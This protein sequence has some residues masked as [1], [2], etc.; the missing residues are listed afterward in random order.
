M[1]IFFILSAFPLFLTAQTKQKKLL[2]VNAGADTTI[3]IAC[4]TGITVNCT[5]Y[6][7]DGVVTAYRWTKISGPGVQLIEGKTRALATITGLQKGVYYF[8]I[9][10]TDGQAN[11]AADTIMITARLPLNHTY[12]QHSGAPVITAGSTQPALQGKDT[13]TVTGI[14]EEL[15]LQG[16]DGQGCEIVIDARGAVQTSPSRFHQPEWFDL[17]FVKLLGLKSY[18]WF[19]TIK[20]S[21][22]IND[23]IIESC[24]FI[25]PP[26]QYKNQPLLQFDNASYRQMIFKDN[27][28]QT[29]YNNKIIRSRIEGFQDIA[30]VIFGS[31]WSRGTPEINRSI[32]LDGEMYLDTIRNITNTNSA[33]NVVS[34]TGFNMK[35]HDCVLD[36]TE[37]NPGARR[38]N[39]AAEVLW[40]GSI[41]FYNNRM[42][43]NY[44]AALRSIALGWTGLPGYRDASVKMYNNIIH[45]QLSYSAFEVGRN[46]AGGRDSAHGFLPIPC[47]CINNTVDSTVR[48][49]YN[50]DYYGYVLDIVNT[51]L[52]NITHTDSVF[53]FNNVVADPE[54]DRAY[55]SAG[56]RY[57]VAIVSKAPTELAMGDNKV[58]RTFSKTVFTSARH[59]AP[60]SGS[61]LID[62]APREFNFRKTDINGHGKTGKTF[63]LGAVEYSRLIMEDKKPP[64]RKKK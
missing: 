45:K 53:C 19:G 54:Y 24:R 16:L 39:H 42:S 41:D 9:T 52:D 34:G 32:F 15:S 48:N 61:P 2:R 31:Y 59:F 58:F 28:Q 4:R 20:A 60:A 57:V 13:I 30:P 36:S 5:V 50:G 44:A 40:Y 56:R 26:G 43:N 63:D 49:S 64:G 17:H 10:I 51:G 1:R 8:S 3:P 11:T 33:I 7:G 37:A 14:F 47:Y 22:Y 12:N 27:K 29:F 62:K 23:F 21:Y 35:I 18:N 25:N 6:G 46:G 38:N 55:D